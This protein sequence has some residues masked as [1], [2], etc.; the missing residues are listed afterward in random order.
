MQLSWSLIVVDSGDTAG[1]M[2]IMDLI[3]TCPLP[4]LVAPEF[5][6]VLGCHR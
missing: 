5:T 4:F 6:L 3:T 2:E 1:L